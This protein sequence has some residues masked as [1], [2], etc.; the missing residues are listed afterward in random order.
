MPSDPTGARVVGIDQLRHDCDLARSPSTCQ[1][2][3]GPARGRAWSSPTLG[4]TWRRGFRNRPPRSL[5]L[6]V[7]PSCQ[8]SS[9]SLPT[10]PC[11]PGRAGE[12]DVGLDGARHGLAAF[13]RVG[14]ETRS[15]PIPDEDAL[16]S[17]LDPRRATR[18]VREGL[19][20]GSGRRG[21]L[22]GSLCVLRLAGQRVHHH[23]RVGA[24]E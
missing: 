9:R 21:S 8:T 19:G 3:A 1:D 4:A 24:Q 13:L 15:R 22:R 20:S 10:A 14:R 7:Q 18:R 16:R 17:R 6:I 2:R 23:P 5:H 11:S 12:L